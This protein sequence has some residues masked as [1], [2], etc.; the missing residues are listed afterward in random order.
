MKPPLAGQT[1]LRS[2]EL[3]PLKGFT[4]TFGI[5]RNRAVSG[6][7]GRR[8]AVE[9]RFSAH[10]VSQIIAGS[11]NGHFDARNWGPYG[12]CRLMPLFHFECAQPQCEVGTHAIATA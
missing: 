4:F 12:V 8:L 7:A 6:R 9:A 2:G 5:G 11:S 3:R 10:I 1:A